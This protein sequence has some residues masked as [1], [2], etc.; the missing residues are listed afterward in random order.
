[1]LYTLL[2]RRLTFQ[3]S[4]T[5]VQHLACNIWRHLSSLPPFNDR[6]RVVGSSAAYLCQVFTLHS[7]C[8]THVAYVAKLILAWGNALFSPQVRL[9]LFSTLTP[10]K[11]GCDAMRCET[12]LRSSSEPRS[13]VPY[14]FI[15]S[16]QQ[17]GQQGNGTLPNRM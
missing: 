5:S 9:H 14:V 8:W 10:D 12:A 7:A 15:A 6:S 2:A 16:G 3:P 13:G 17:G 11:R 1:M 4:A